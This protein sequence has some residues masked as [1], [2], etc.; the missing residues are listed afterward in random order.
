M[1]RSYC[2][3][4]SFLLLLLLAGAFPI[5]G[6]NNARLNWYFGNSDRGIRFNRGTHTVT[7]A[8][9]PAPSFGTGGG[10]VASNPINGNLL[11]FTDGTVIYDASGAAMPN[12]TGLSGNP[13]GNQPAVVAAVPGQPN[14]Y[15]VF[16]NTA[17]YTTGG[18]IFLTTVDMSLPG[19]GGTGAPPP[20]GDVTSANVPIPTL[21]NRSEAMILIPHANGTDYWLV[22]HENGTA[23][24]TVSHI[25]ATGVVTSTNYQNEGFAMSAGNF[26]YNATTG[27]IAVSPQ[28]ANVGVHLMNFNASTGELEFDEVIP[29]TA[30][31]AT[32]GQ[33]IY[34][35]EWSS[36]GR[37]LYISIAGEPGIQADVLQYDSQNPSATL[38]SVLPQPNSI[39]N[40]YGL[41]MGPDSVIYHLYQET[42]GGPYLLGALSN[43]D[44]V[45]S[46]VNYNPQVFSGDFGGTQFPSFLPRS[47]QDVTVDFT[48]SGQC[49]NSPVSFFPE[50]D[51][52]ADSLTWNFGD[53]T[54][55]RLWSPNHIYE[56][57]SIYTVTLTAWLD[58]EPHVVQH[59]INITQFDL[60]INLVQDTTA[61]SCELPFPK[62]P[63]PPP[64]CG[65]F[66]VTA[67]VQGG[68]GIAEWSNGQT[69]LTLQPD[70]AGYYYVIVT[71][72]NTGC[73]AYAGVNINEYGFQDQRAN[74]WHFGQGA[75]LDFNPYNDNPPVAIPGFV[76][77]PEGT[78]TISDRNGKVIFS[79]DGQNIYD[80][81]G[82][83]ITPAPNPP[84]L[85][86]NPGATQSVLIMPVA[87][88]ETLYYIFTTQEVYGTGTYELRYSL[89]DL[90]IGENG[91]LVEYNVLLFSPS[92][93]RITGNG[94][95]LIAHEYGNNS[96]RAYRVTANGIENPVITGAGSDHSFS[97]EES[98]QGY[99]KLG[100]GN[101]LAVALSTPGAN[102]IEVFDFDNTTGVVSN[103]QVLDLDEPNGQVYGIEFSPSGNKLFA[104]VKGG[105]SALY[106]FAFD[107][108]GNGY[109]KQG[110]VSTPGGGEPGA[111]QMG[112][113][114]Q[115]YM[116]VN[117]SSSLW[118]FQANEDTTQVTNLANMQELPLVGGSSSTLGLPNFIQNISTPV[119]G[120][121]ISVTGTCLGSPTQFNGGGRDPNIEFYSWNFGD[122]TSP[123]PFVTDPNAEHQYDAPGT[124]QVALTLRN[125]C[126]IDTTLLTTVVITAPPDSSISIVGGGFPVLCDGP[127]TIQAD[128][129]DPGLIYVWST[130]DSTRQ[131]QVN[132]QGIYTVTIIDGVG[133]TSSA[134]ILVADNRPI[135]ELGPDLTVCQDSP[136][137]PLDAQNPGA[138]Y[139]WAVDGT[140]VGTNRTQAVDTSTPGVFEYT[141]AVTDP[142]TSCTIRDTVTFTINP[143]PVFT[144]TAIDPSSC[145]A[146]DGG[147][148]ISIT[149]P[150]TSLFTYS[151]TA[152]ST[153][154]NVS[155]RTIGLYNV[156]S[157][158][159]GTYT[160]TVADQLSGC[161]E[162]T[163][164]SINDDEFDVT[165]D[166][167]GPCDP[168]DL[169]VTT[170]PDQASGNYRV[171][172]ADTG[173]PVITGPFSATGGI[174]TITNIPGPSNNRNYIVEVRSS[175]GCVVSSAPT[176][177]NLSD[178]V[179]VSNILMD[180][181]SEPLT[182][183]VVADA[184][185]IIT[186][187]GPGVPA[188][189]TGHTLTVANAPQGAQQFSFHAEQA[190]FCALDS[191]FT[192]TVDNTMVPMLSQSSA[193]GDQVTITATPS[194]PYLYRWF[195]DGA[196]D[197]NLA[198][199]QV[200]A[201]EL[202]HG[203][204]YTVRIYNPVTGCEPN[205]QPLVVS[206]IGSLELDLEVGLACQG[207]PFTI[208]GTTNVPA[209][210]EWW[211]EGAIINGQTSST[212]TDTRAGN[213]EARA[214]FQGC[215]AE[216]SIEVVLQP[217]TPGSLPSG[218]T[219]CNDPANAD[220]ET[221]QVDLDPGA[222]FVSYT[223]FKDGVPLGI[224]D[225]VLTVTEPGT[226]RVDL[227]NS[228]GCTSSDQTIVEV[229]CF[230]K[231]VVPNAFSPSGSLEENREFYAFTYFID[232]TD[233]EVL[234]FS[235]WGELIFQ[236]TDRLFRWNGGYNNNA[237]RPLPPGT[238]AYVI[239]YKSSYQPERGI[240][241]KRGGV[242]LL[243]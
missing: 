11:F 180:A 40:S 66:S 144:A 205:S 153:Q 221:R 137:T 196:F 151:V 224:T 173:Q 67:T 75:G 8:D 218:A 78:A 26:A 112:P 48:W 127:V 2:F 101:K 121:T 163:T 28:S 108:L 96:F 29:N 124:Y 231:I 117:G 207:S 79:T 147:I 189:T 42:V 200:I 81:E 171:I 149:D 111:L 106:E 134:G 129:D 182:I 122:G 46:A 135:V 59:D 1:R 7:Q 210:Y 87:G 230:P 92:T 51:P 20:L 56:S 237:S 168:I 162:V 142:I 104:T 211:Y 113:N 60:Q 91:G 80:K 225:Q 195:R 98:A 109:Y 38:Q 187:S 71:D 138:T 17:D 148:N 30:V 236:S 215:V 172:D 223:W 209:T 22:T 192:V 119:Q 128:A 143:T 243:R 181:C 161:S 154:I 136:V 212:L 227:V 241:E 191:T 97:S 170:D 107:S 77:S 44:T 64:Q 31:A 99:M 216:E 72:P 118:Y 23:N 234:I 193:C 123:T 83:N 37:Y 52:A 213:Y 114:G 152:P 177:V 159:A 133:C 74:I 130:G 35:V 43:T 13:S 166:P 85:G 217:V 62:A 27:Q 131:I 18:D 63:N 50:V 174:F 19:N 165:V 4:Q 228:V 232:D 126:D 58:G 185:A 146:G 197:P 70:S 21:T 3:F 73:S 6:Q 222:D 164:A 190:G 120:P 202:N 16:T 14:Q 175:T 132:R 10:A 32:T 242:V 233:F 155:D 5:R 183:E 167:V 199:P 176:F 55:S 94:E 194:G 68:T 139:E 169:E 9:N 53:Q 240:Q 160:I 141:V 36:D 206:V 54:G 57:G 140:T 198:G 102:V 24:Y 239:K 84:G 25:D 34:D 90:K 33:A 61:C 184:Q 220:E 95:W 186:W 49:A 65:Q 229:E 86:G 12:G 82:N 235:R 100:P 214:F 69:G 238:Y 93:E 125:R 116:A 178:P 110:P 188:G 157:L 47:S 179:P 39:A 103:P 203:Q 150:T 204:E 89:F 115:I 208:T 158:N 156:P 88:D 226:Y 76:N 45:A 219:I 15:F 41:Q 201:T 145:G 105:P